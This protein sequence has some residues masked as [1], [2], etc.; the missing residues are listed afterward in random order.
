MSP[1]SCVDGRCSRR[2]AVSF[3]AGTGRPG[4]SETLA[5]P[6]GRHAREVRRERIGIRGGARPGVVRASRRRGRRAAAAGARRTASSASVMM[7]MT[8]AARGGEALLGGARVVEA[9]GRRSRTS[10]ARVPGCGASRDSRGGAFFAEEGGETRV[11]PAGFVAGVL[12][13][14][15]PCPERR[16]VVLFEDVGPGGRRADASPRARSRRAARAARR[17]AP[18]ASPPPGAPAPRTRGRTPSRIART[19][20][21]A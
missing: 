8:R 15:A 14:F 18:V 2:T 5:A 9:G 12:G 21:A 11:A 19:P 4:T 16:F 10:G 1:H 20:R 13:V 7:M 6:R 3:G 17:R